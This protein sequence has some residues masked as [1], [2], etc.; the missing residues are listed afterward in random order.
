MRINKDEKGIVSIV[1]TVI[2]LLVITITSL[3]FSRLAQREQRQALDRQLSTQAYYAAEAG[4]NDAKKII[5]DTTSAYY[6][7]NKI[8]CRDAGTNQ[9]PEVFSGVMS[10]IDLSTTFA[11]SSLGNITG[12]AEYSCVLIRHDPEELIFDV[13]Q[14]NGA[15]YADMT[16]VDNSGSPKDVNYFKITWTTK[17]VTTGRSTGGLVPYGN[18]VNAEI[19]MLRIDL[20]HLNLG[21]DRNS[22]QDNTMTAFLYP[23][24]NSG[25][26]PQTLN[27]GNFVG[28]NR[29]D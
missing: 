6:A 26:S 16:A 14:D 7:G 25:S 10:K 19:G 2:V 20:T 12:A 29:G 8:S 11:P 4:I 27:F 15:K 1:V 13:G 9:D 18:W 24:S 22:L 21:F 3:G 23:R 28:T 17:D 5:G